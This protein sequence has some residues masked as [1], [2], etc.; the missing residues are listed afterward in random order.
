MTADRLLA[1]EHELQKLCWNEERPRLLKEAETIQDELLGKY[2]VLW[3][4]YSTEACAMEQVQAQLQ[5]H[6]QQLK[7][8]HEQERHNH[9]IKGVATQ[10]SSSSYKRHCPFASVSYR[11]HW[12]SSKEAN[13]A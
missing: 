6:E 1:F 4:T 9:G 13:H 7:K 11:R 2:N 5:A 8:L 3:R 12:Q 10:S